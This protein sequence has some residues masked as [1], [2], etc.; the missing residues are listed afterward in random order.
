MQSERWRTCTDI[1]HAALERAPAER[2]AFLEESCAEDAELRRQVDLLLKYHEE[3][4]EFIASPAVAQTP[5][6][7]AD[8]PD[9][10]IGQHLGNYRIDGVLGV[11]GMGV[12]YL[13]H[14]ERLGRKVGLKLLPRA[15]VRDETQLERLKFEA[16]TAS[17]LNHPNIVTVH[18]IGQVESTHY[19]AIEFIEGVTLRER[20][21]RAPVPPDEILEIAIQVASALVVAHRAGIVHR[22]I[23]PENIM[24]RP[25]GYVKV[26]DFGIAKS[27]H[28]EALPGM[29]AGVSSRK[30][31]LGLILGTIR[32]MSPEQARGEVVDARSDVWSLGVVLYEMLAGTL[33]FDGQTPHQVREALL[34][35]E[36]QPLEAEDRTSAPSLHRIVEECLRKDPGERFQTSE[37]LLAALREAREGDRERVRRNRIW[38]AVGLALLLAGIA[39]L[40]TSLLDKPAEK[41]GLALGRPA[42]IAVNA[43][44]TVYVA[45]FA[46]HAIRQLAPGG[47]LTNLAGA[48]GVIGSADGVSTVA[49]FFHPGD[50]GV[51]RDGNIYVADT[52]NHLI[53]RV[54]PAGVVS[55]VAG[56]ASKPGNDDGP[57]QSARFRFPTG[58]ALD[59]AGNI[60]VADY[61]N[62]TIR[63]IAPDGKVSTFAGSAGEPGSADGTGAAARFNQVHG[64]AAD[65]AG[66]VYAADFGNHTIRK[67]TP[68]GV[69][70]TLAGL[71]G[72]PGNVDGQGSAARF[73]APYDVTI[74]ENGNVYVADTSNHTIR[75]I[76]PAGMVSTLAGVAGNVGSTDGI[77]GEAKFAVPAGVTTD[78]A[79]NIYVA[80]FGNQALRKITPTAAVTTMSIRAEPPNESSR[81]SIAV[82]P[83]ADLSP[84]RDQQYFSDGIAEEILN[85]LAHVKDL[86]VAG[87]SSSFSFRGRNEDLRSIG[88]ALG[89]DHI[90]E[91]SVR[92]Q[93]DKVRITAQLIQVSDGFHLWSDTFDGNL[94]DVFSLQE[95][96][97]RAITQQ[98]QVVL[99][100][101]QQSQLVKAATSS[102]EAYGLFLQATAIFNRRDGAR[103]PDAIAQ[104][105]QALRLDPKFARA[106]ARLASLVSIARG[107]DVPLTENPGD[108]VT[109]EAGLAIELD[110]T[111]AEPHAAL[112]QMLFTQRRFN[113]AR[114]AYARALAIDATDTVANFW[115]GTLLSSTGHPKESAAALDIVLANDPMLPNAL[116]WRGWVHLQSGELDEA[117]RSFRRA[118]DAGLT[119]VGLAFAHIAQAR[120]DK[121]ALIDWLARGLE[122]FMRDLPTG[123]SRI[124]AAGT[125]GTSEEHAQA[126]A[127]IGDYLATQPEVTSGAIPLALIWLGE[128]KRAL[129]VAQEK[130]T[131]NDTLFLPSL[132]ANAGRGARTLPEFCVFVRQSGLAEFWDHNGP[133]VLCR[134]GQSGD[135]ICE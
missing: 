49:R 2:S 54:T 86:K 42:G 7:L 25:D 107:Y 56:Q 118:A 131:R 50:V 4:G 60:Y 105:Q 62:H 113:D 75:K 95:R 26:L 125:V 88:A 34:R 61:G 103:F 73:S 114:A 84:G 72:N 48:T 40:I 1:F 81:K 94:S 37:Q 91:G 111:L 39:Y 59:Q 30:T 79:G 110:S 8:D 96:I 133:P 92:T 23:K 3:A 17:A 21:R 46:Q 15:F 20:I 53:R 32:Y 109:R 36:P 115:L 126:T 52:N 112:G 44:G 74:D 55:T 47:A 29:D 98:L 6:F 58:I 99:H 43:D 64:L 67:I 19:I 10:L 93:G 14:D 57:A 132:W 77:G 16:R 97:A 104:L 45:D 11:G 119:S 27:S 69:V 5:E 121:A 82:L 124:I 134:K 135:Y 33:P 24:I 28:P 87:R 63:K 108:I 76:T 41:A 123:T 120:G 85:A 90:L 83:F 13:A 89:V 122:P 22:D 66:N 9:A 78:H 31:Q 35:D 127:L 116:L 12:V 106:H 129:A 102:T 18:E 71:A 51:G 38:T 80:D 100:G 70:T 68:H 101:D 130:P 117:E 128:P 65:G